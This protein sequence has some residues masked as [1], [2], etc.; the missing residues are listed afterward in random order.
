MLEAKTCVP[1]QR[2]APPLDADEVDKLSKETPG[3]EVF[4][5]RSKIQ[6]RYSFNNFVDAMAFSQKV[7]ELCETEG[8]HADI[9]FGWGYCNILFYTHKIKGLHEN[10]FIMAAKTDALS[11]AG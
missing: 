7:G 2:G 6:R 8:H 4:D 3:W 5:G 10:D 1:C 9:T 11:N